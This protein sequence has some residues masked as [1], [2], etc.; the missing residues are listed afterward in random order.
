MGTVELKKMI[1]QYMSTADDKLLKI[2][3]AVFESYQKNKEIDFFD[4]LPLEIQ[5]LLIESRKDIKKGNYFSNA[6]VVAEAKEKYN[7]S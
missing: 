1:T 6:D 3:K 5:D 7:I 4:E 2:V